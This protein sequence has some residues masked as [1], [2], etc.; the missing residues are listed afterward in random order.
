MEEKIKQYLRGRLLPQLK[1]K[2][3]MRM[4]TAPAVSG[5]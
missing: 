5:L 3:D 4:E 1:Q 2:T